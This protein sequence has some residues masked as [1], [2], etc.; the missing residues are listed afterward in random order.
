VISTDKSPRPPKA[1]RDGQR[2][3]QIVAAA[4]ACVLLHGF[5]ATTMAQIS[6]Q[7][8]MSV[9]QIY[10][11]FASKDAVIKAIVEHI[12]S[13][14]LAQV[15]NDTAQADLPRVLAGRMF[16]DTHRNDHALLL[17]VTAEATRNPAV[18]DIVRKADRRLHDQVVAALQKR[19]PGLD[20]AD[21]SARV[22]VIAVLSQGTA[23]R[24]VTDQP[25]DPA[26][27]GALYREV[28]DRLLPATLNRS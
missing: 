22:E 4:R 3:A 15:G 21:I 26:L 17:E 25:A 14:Q 7:A 19:H 23:F 12:I 27:L 2:R 1:E 8:G 18:A 5:H 28:I 11:Y 13:A 20:A 24:R 10:R 6:K 9:G 16:T